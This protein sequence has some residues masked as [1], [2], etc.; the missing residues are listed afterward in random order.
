LAPGGEA[1]AGERLYPWLAAGADKPASLARRI[2]AP[3]GFARAPA[4]R[5][6]FAD[7]LRH[8]PLKPDG[9]PVRLHDG[10]LKQGQNNH[11]AVV[12]LDIG[13]RNLQQCADA[14]MRLRAE[15]LYSLGRY[16]AIAFKFTS[17]DRASFA[18]WAEGWRPRVRGNRV[19]WVR[20]GR[21]GT[22]HRN[23]RAYLDTVFTYA[24]SY[25]LSRELKPVAG[26]GR[27]RIGDVF[28]EGGFPGHAILVVDLAVEPGSGRKV[29][30]LAQSFMP[31]QSL[32]IIKNP[33]D[34]GLGPW[35]ELPPGRKLVTPD[36]T[37]AA[38]HLR[39]F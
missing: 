8:L 14:V 9:A 31:A 13:R 37:F 25:S 6:S 4:A 7:W 5:G 34:S 12:A 2:A 36:W 3:A 11:A 24:G 35:F 19:R 39:R 20:G 26:P 10:R 38:R 15:Y 18:R 33:R 27:I 28:I 21:T 16:R 1:I 30:L 17:G 23:F 22:G 32:H 29:F